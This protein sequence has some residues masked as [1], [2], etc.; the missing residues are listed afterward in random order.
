MDDED[1]FKVNVQMFS[2]ISSNDSEHSP[3]SSVN[4]LKGLQ[5]AEF[6][7][8]TVELSDK[9]SENNKLDGKLKGLSISGKDVKSVVNDLSQTAEVL[10]EDEVDD[11]IEEDIVDETLEN[12][13]D[14]RPR[15]NSRNQDDPERDRSLSART[16]SEFEDETPR[17][18]HDKNQTRS[19]HSYT[20]DFSS[21]SEVKS[22]SEKSHSYTYSEKKNLTSSKPSRSSRRSSASRSSR[23][24]HSSRTSHS[25]RSRERSHSKSTMSEYSKSKVP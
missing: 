7:L 12:M 3:E 21:G 4:P 11:E 23:S 25:S 5:M 14:L 22:Q 8:N 2:E 1:D 19:E 10:T 18:K 16:I 9:L 20:N 24:S 13:K 6:A 17:S 15:N